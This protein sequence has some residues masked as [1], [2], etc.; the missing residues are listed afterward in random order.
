MQFKV[1]TTISIEGI[2][3]RYVL[4]EHKVVIAYPGKTEVEYSLD[5]YPLGIGPLG[6]K[7]FV[8]A[9]KLP[10]GNPYLVT[11]VSQDNTC[12]HIRTGTVCR[13]RYDTLFAVTGEFTLFPTGEQDPMHCKSTK[14][15]GT[16]LKQHLEELKGRTIEAKGTLAYIYDTD[17]EVFHTQIEANMTARYRASSI[18]FFLTFPDGSL[19]EYPASLWLEKI[20]IEEKEA[21]KN[22]RK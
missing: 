3:V 19:R 22:K 1:G 4:S 16:L 6:H 14:W 21:L 9:D 13:V 2:L 11:S 8:P 15:S 17:R 12:T 7:G 20:T 5:Y 18:F 10:F